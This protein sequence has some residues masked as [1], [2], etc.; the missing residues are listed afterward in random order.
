MKSC[1]DSP[2]RLD[3]QPSWR[4]A[5]PAIKDCV[6]RGFSLGFISQQW[7]MSVARFSTKTKLSS[8]LSW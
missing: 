6:A 7:R 8:G 4:R 2:L 1:A 3:I 5:R